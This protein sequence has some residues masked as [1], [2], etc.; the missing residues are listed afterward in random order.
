LVPSELG[1]SQIT[2]DQEYSCHERKANEGN[3]QLESKY[4]QE[5]ERR[6]RIRC[7]AGINK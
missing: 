2:F 7:T 6:S 4:K 5:T 1:S 3:R